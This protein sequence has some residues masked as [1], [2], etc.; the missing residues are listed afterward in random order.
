MVYIPAGDFIMGSHASDPF[1]DGDEV[2]AHTVFIDA[3]WMDR[4]EV[5]N[6]MY[7]RCISNGACTPPAQ[8]TYYTMEKYSD[9]PVLGVSWE[10]ANLYCGWAGRRLPT[11][12]EWEKAA[13]GMDSRMYPWGNE[14]PGPELA[15]FARNIDATSPVGSYP[16]GASFYGALDMAGNAWEW[17][18]D[19][20]SAE[21]YS[22]SAIDNPF[23]D[24]PVNQRVLR[25]GNWDSNAEGIRSANR[26]W[27]FPGRN[28]T[29]GFRC[30]KSY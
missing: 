12:A 11:E 7:V 8:T 25:G 9:H 3:F 22:T 18:A 27:A 30:A 5:A 14:I 10:Q 4:T 15:N 28:D 26:F 20:Y 29:D 13:R 16:R 21:Y 1:A 19:G 17:V 23:S 24:S 2:P 6:S